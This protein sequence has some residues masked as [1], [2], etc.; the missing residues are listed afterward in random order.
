MSEDNKEKPGAGG[1]DAQQ[2]PKPAARNENDNGNGGRG[3]IHSKKNRKR[4]KNSMDDEEEDSDID[5]KSGDNNNRNEIV[6]SVDYT[7]G[8]V[9]LGDD[10]LPCIYF[11]GNQYCSFSELK[12]GLIKGDF[13][14]GSKAKNI[15]LELKD[16]LDC[17]NITEEKGKGYKRR[18]AEEAESSDEYEERR[19]KIKTRRRRQYGSSVVS[20]LINYILFCLFYFVF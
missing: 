15:F 5:I 12:D 11:N 14:A 2:E 20:Y 13:G 1:G 8:K 3:S 18:N 17:I 7:F 16:A 19:D 6:S 9:D 4:G 10:S